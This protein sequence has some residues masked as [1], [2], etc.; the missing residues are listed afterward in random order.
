MRKYL[1][2]L[3]C[4]ITL[5]ACDKHDPILPGVRTAIFD[6]VHVDVLNK[7]IS[8]VPET[9]HIIDN[10]NCPYTQ[11]A[12]NIIKNGDRR[13][14]SG[15]PTNNTV[16]TKQTPICNGKYLFATAV[17]FSKYA[18]FSSASRSALAVRYSSA[19]ISCQRL[20]SF[21]NKFLGCAISIPR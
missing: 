16:A 19:R 14:F 21:G 9:A 1:L 20:N 15:F 8:D 18:F 11:D 2:I 7:T 17:N 13:I 6:S 4:G 5:S 10:S 12:S 3:F